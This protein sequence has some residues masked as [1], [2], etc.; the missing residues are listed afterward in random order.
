M[1]GIHYDL[2][3]LYAANKDFAHA[4]GELALAFQRPSKALDD[5]IAQDIEEG[6][7]LYNL[8]TTPPFDKVLNDLL[9]NITLVP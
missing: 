9:L 1:C 5:R 8:A 6:G 7:K 4:T 3:C 2:A